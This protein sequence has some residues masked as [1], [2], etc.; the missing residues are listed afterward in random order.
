[1]MHKMNLNPWVTM[2][3]NPRK[4]IR[5]IVNIAPRKGMFLLAFFF[6]L[7]YLLNLAHTMSIGQNFSPLMILISAV[8]LAPLIGYFWFYVFG[9]CLYW[10]GKLFKGQGK[11]FQ[12]LSSVAW[13]SIPYILNVLMWFLF[14]VTSTFTIFVKNSEGFT[15]FFINFITL[16]TAIW[17]LVLVIKC[18][19]E[20]Q[21]FSYWKSIGNYLA[22]LVVYFIIL[23]GIGAAFAGIS[24]LITGVV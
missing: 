9:G 24:Y 11:F 2:W 20:V 13:S 5:E 3:T 4:T 8:I 21:D 23:F 15:F 12:I 7:Q 19:K 6:G 14:L 22:A 16:I 18:I 10:T 1:M 17:S